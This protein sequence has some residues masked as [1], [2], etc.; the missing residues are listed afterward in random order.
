MATS[1]ASDIACPCGGQAKYFGEA[2][3]GSLKCDTCGQ[4]LF[5][6]GYEFLQSIRERWL[7]G[8][9]GDVT[10]EAGNEINDN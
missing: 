9:R 5:G 7:R 2:L 8:E 4:Y 1:S 6:V 10:E 3:M